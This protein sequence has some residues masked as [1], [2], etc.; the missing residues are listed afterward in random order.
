MAAPESADE[1]RRAVEAR[2]DGISSMTANLL[3]PLSKSRSAL[4]NVLT[5]VSELP[6]PTAR[7][8]DAE[9][10][11]VADPDSRVAFLVP[12]LRHLNW[13][14]DI[15][16]NHL[17][18]GTR[19]ELSQSLMDEVHTEL[20]DLGLG[21]YEVVIAH[22]PANNF[23]T[24][25][26]D[27]AGALLGPL[28]TI[29]AVAP[30]APGKFALFR[31]PRIEGTS[32]FW[33]PILL[34]HEV[35]HVAVRE[36]NTVAM[37]G[38]TPKFMASD[39]SPVVAPGIDPASPEAMQKVLGLHQVA[40]NWATEL[41]CDV[42]ALRRF[43]P[44]AI[45]ALA[46]Y[47][48]SL[49]PTDASSTTHPPT[50]LR[51]RLLLDLSGAVASP[52]LAP[53]VSAWDALTPAAPSFGDPRVDH[54][55]TLFLSHEADLLL[56]TEQHGTAQ[57][58]ADDRQNVI[59]SV[60]DSFAEHLPARPVLRLPDG[61][62]G[63]ATTADVVNAA[64]VARNEGVGLGVGE[65]AEKTV[66]DHEFVRRWI[67]NG[68]SMPLDLYQTEVPG[69]PEPVTAALGRDLIEQRLK[70][71][72]AGALKVIP[73]LHRPKGAG[74]DLRLGNRFIVFRRTST[75]YFD[76]L[77]VDSDP[78][79]VQVFFQ[80]NWN[81]DLVLHPNELVLGATLEYLRLP[82]DLSGQVIT[83]SS[84]GRLGLLSATA[85][86]VHPHF[87]GCLTL[88]LVNL[89]TIPI[90][91]SPGERVAQL[92]LSRA[93]GSGGPEAEDEKYRDPIGPQFSKVRTDDEAKV[94]W[95]IRNA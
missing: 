14:A 56:A 20:S 52:R 1:L 31:V 23:K 62:F 32:V 13:V 81:E 69:Q 42:Q 65:L 70:R 55:S 35:A 82:A 88:E 43:G 71:S 6:E 8:V 48:V 25:H 38:L 24:M 80:L 94:I 12:I 87:R 76:P 49:G 40:I 30:P 53:L 66:Q 89:S 79:A 5:L 41:L 37:F 50:D 92:V 83:R 91:L 2:L 63:S 29:G 59:E 21:E 46:E 57:Y 73:L 67:T 15:V 7:A 68:G 72:D 33:R 58:Q 18:H 95:S 90:R 84:Y 86:Q 61:S 93:E 64:W 4:R 19:Q 44:S 60:A 22:G 45:A 34:G 26:G 85:V 54:L 3:G 9:W 10:N 78:R 27:I 28:V 75:A 74:L 17:A 16:E 39:P 51:L 36:Y 11:R 47:F 77:E